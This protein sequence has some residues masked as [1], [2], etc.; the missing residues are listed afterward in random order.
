MVSF[1]EQEINKNVASPLWTNLFCL[2][3]KHLLMEELF[4][5]CY[6]FLIFQDTNFLYLHNNLL[7]AGG[8]P[9]EA[10]RATEFQS[11]T[12]GVTHKT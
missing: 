7:L 10:Q 11:F 1:T 8:L 6:I 4:D 2:K 9:E 12:G 5:D 3:W